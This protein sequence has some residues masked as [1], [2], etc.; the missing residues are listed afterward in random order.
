LPWAAWRPFLPG[1][2]AEHRLGPAHGGLSAAGADIADVRGD[3][4]AQGPQSGN[5]PGKPGNGTQQPL[6][7]GA[8]DRQDHQQGGERHDAAG[9]GHN[10]GL[11]VELGAE[12]AEQQV[13]GEAAHPTLAGPGSR[14]GERGDREGRK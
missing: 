12:P 6:P 1:S 11:H 7:V 8:A 10:P 3:R 4:R 13:A 2:G 5:L 9:E 14:S